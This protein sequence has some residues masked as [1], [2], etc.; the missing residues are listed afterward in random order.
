MRF[1]KHLFIS[2]AHLDNQPLAPEQQGWITRFHA[3][4]SAMLS[5]RLGRQAEIWRDSKLN[6]NDIFADEIVQQFPKTELLISILT[7]RY[8]ESEWCTR[9]VREFCRSAEHTGGLIVD[10]KTRVIKVIKIPIENE[11][12]L[13]PV[14]KQALGYPFFVFD[15][16]ETPLELDPAYGGEFQQKFNLKMAKLA[17]DITQLIKLIGSNAADD[18]PASAPTADKP[19]VYLGECS[20]DVREEREALAIDL[21]LHG[22]TIYPDTKLPD[23]EIAY[24]TEVDRM[25]GLCKLAIHPIGAVYGAVPD[26]NSEQSITVL[27]NRVAIQQC[28]SRELPRLIWIPRPARP[29]TPRQQEFIETLSRDPEAQFGADVITAD[30]EALK[31]AVHA[32]LKKIETPPPVAAPNA[33][34]TTAIGSS[35]K[36]VFV[37]CD[38]RDRKATIPIRKLLKSRGFETSIPLFEGDAATVRQASQ[39]AL[40]SCDAVLLF[41]GSADEAWKRCQEAELKKAQAYRESKAPLTV[42]TCLSEP[43]TE[44]KQEMIELEE[45]RLIDCLQGLAEDKF[46]DFIRAVNSGAPA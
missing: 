14:M 46:G 32:A 39:D 24:I 16:Q 8:L 5:M 7:P 9:E 17:F 11:D 25:M 30:I 36:S 3:S 12:P 37:L 26:G 28:R 33:S 44:S 21:R 40:A 27:Q 23:E 38:E 22:Y 15:E 42:Y 31:A 1:E 6:G 20:F 13:P 29:D 18:N 34:E 10:N 35:V 41:Y 43:V 19:A 45:P 4:L 2:Y